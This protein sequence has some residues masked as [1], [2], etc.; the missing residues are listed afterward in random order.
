MGAAQQFRA[1]LR[2]NFILYKRNVGSTI[3]SLLVPIL[4]IALL[5]LMQLA[6]QSNQRRNASIAVVRNASEEKINDIPRCVSGEYGRCYTLGYTSNSDP[7]VV[8]LINRIAL[9]NNIPPEEIIGFKTEPEANLFL[10]QNK[11]ST[12]GLFHVIIDYGCNFN[13]APSA[14][15]TCSAAVHNQ[16]EIL[17]IKYA[18]QYNTSGFAVR[19]VVVN[20]AKYLV[21]P[22]QHA[23]HRAALSLFGNGVQ[24][25]I[26]IM[27]FPHPAISPT[28]IVSTAGPFVIFGALMFNFVIQIGQLVTEKQT[29]LRESM[30]VM[31][32]AD[33]IF[34]STWLV[35][36]VTTN[37]I[38]IALLTFTGLAFQ[39]DFF[40]KNDFGTYAI[41]FLLFSFAMVPLA[42][43]VS[44]LVDDADTSTLAGFG[45][46][47]IGVFM[48]SFASF[49]FTED[50]NP[51]I[52][53]VFSLFPFVLLAKGLG[54]LGEDTASELDKGLR[55][56]E[57]SDAE[58][59]FFPLSL[60]YGLLAMNFFLYLLLAIYVDNVRYSGRSPFFFF[61]PSYWRGSSSKKKPKTA[62]AKE[63]Y[64]V[65]MDQLDEDV[66][67][68]RDFVRK[69]EFDDTVSVIIS[70]LQKTY[71]NYT[72]GCCADKGSAFRAV[73]GI[74]LVMKQG[75]LFC[76]LGHNGAGKTTTIGM[77]TG[78]FP[79]SGGDA[80]IFGNS[81]TT[82]MNEIRK[83]MGVCPQH[84]IL[85][86]QL[87][88]EEHL[89]L[90]AELRGIPQEK[91][92]QE[93]K[94]RLT[95]VDL[96]SAKDN[97]AGGYSGGM[98]RRLSVA[99][100]LIGD[101]A[102]VFL[103]EPT[104]GMDPV[105]RRKVWNLIE[106]VKRG[107]VTLLTT[108]SMEEADIL[109]DKI[110]IMKDGR[111]ATVG[112]SIRLK[113]RFGTGYGIAVLGKSP[114]DVPAIKQFV[115]DEFKTASKPIVIEDE[116]AKA[117]LGV[118]QF[119][120]P[121]SE[122]KR[123]PSFFQKLEKSRDKIGARDFQVALST[124][125]EVF[126]SIA[127]ID[128]V[129]ETRVEKKKKSRKCLII[130][131]VVL[132]LVVLLVVAGIIFA[133]RPRPVVP[134]STANGLGTEPTIAAVSESAISLTLFPT[135][136]QVSEVTNSTASVT[137]R[138]DASV[139]AVDLTFYVIDPA[140]NKSWV[141]DN[142]INSFK[143]VN[144]TA[145]S[146][147][148][149]IA[150]IYVTGLSVG[151]TYS[152]VASVT[153]DTASFSNATRFRTPFAP[154]APRKFKI[155]ISSGFGSTNR[156]Y[157][158]LVPAANENL[159]F[160]VMVGNSIFADFRGNASDTLPTLHAKYNATLSQS[161]FRALSASTSFYA[162]IGK[163][164]MYFPYQSLSNPAI[165]AQLGPYLFNT[166]TAFKQSWGIGLDGSTQL[167][168]KFS[169]GDAIDLFVIDIR[170]E[171]IPFNTIMSR[172]QM[173]WLKQGLASSTAR[174]KLVAET[175]P[176]S[177]IAEIDAAT[178][179]A[180]VFELWSTYADN[181]TEILQHIED[182]KINGVVFLS[183]GLDYGLMR[184]NA[185]KLNATSSNTQN[186]F[187]I[188]SGPSG[189][190]I[191]SNVRMSSTLSSAPSDYL[192]LLD[193]WTWTLIEGDPVSG[194]L[195]IKFINDRGQ[196][197]RTQ[198]V[199]V[200]KYQLDIEQFNAA[201]AFFR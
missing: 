107:R 84:D 50:V 72:C 170:T 167:Y 161:G 67:A 178:Y 47:L 190:L 10:S 175:L 75:E 142:S 200:D 65:E 172:V 92:E 73:K 127:H 101:P 95:D 20:I 197:L 70:N 185:T 56:S 199:D 99:I 45:L 32:M 151:T 12:Q 59:H 125:E 11:N 57:I 94:D 7:N 51:G 34:W 110:A 18:I 66:V 69:G 55:F 39:F 61:M 28:N 168:R 141:V 150:S 96:T 103:D 60:V 23:M 188:V 29:K 9:Q 16:S 183:G 15:E 76:L 148:S 4:F 139:L 52:H 131:L 53:A 133:V 64:Q 164:E 8:A 140:S 27:D 80:T 13:S 134:E 186:A 97:N 104:T 105:S 144:T 6:V 152:V 132:A 111:L 147:V 46:F 115:L 22:M 98:Q 126:L 136:I 48:Q 177:N 153:N 93:V 159:D 192:L 26:S 88:G 40:L 116:E 118:F 43:F 138:T 79:C 112:T 63:D 122:S 201:A 89:T 145:T 158:N 193:S 41:L 146:N 77:L 196:A 21:L 74:D 166:L 83:V 114:S 124:L 113:N 117:K 82:D 14:I 120:V 38:S 162:Q 184:V 195:T 25:N 123:L 181:R 91:V 176:I 62:K 100:A 24:F 163:Q 108:H 68:E 169:W 102:I 37:L 187:E 30:R 143:G 106:K 189:S 71:L 78:L 157:E 128:D 174:F 49:I 156:P 54:D 35:T 85:W 130:S 137:V 1:L 81:I 90:F 180:L 3:V 129:K 33:W 109:G 87:T 5:F 155:G 179:Q 42:F 191:N 31:G 198:T 44:T 86:K 119:E 165:F 182:N 135:G 121:R 19:G 160:F 149:R 154:S 2:K 173:D 58:K 194:D 17:S 36:N 171:I